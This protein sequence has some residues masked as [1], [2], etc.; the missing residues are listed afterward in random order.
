LGPVRSTNF[1]EHYDVVSMPNPNAVAYTPLG[2]ELHT[3]LANWRLP[4]DFQTLACLKSSVHGG[5]SLLA[6]G[7]KVAE[8]LRR[9]HPEAF[10]LL[11]EQ[12]VEFR[13]HDDSCDI[14]TAVPPITLAPDGRIIQI[15]FNNWLRAYNPLPPKRAR[16]LHAALAAWW[17]LLRLPQNHLNLRLEPGDLI[18]YHNHRVLHG[19][20]P[21]D[22]ASGERHL[23][24]CYVELEDV[25]STWRRL[26]RSAG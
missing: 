14:R 11:T 13:F 26:V 19:R 15:R 6:D 5:E 24:G 25:Q 10:R 1:G 2:L 20:A 8:D 22:A 16:E 7:F 23:Q 18:V 3:D 4:P 21:F 12:P 17:R 9:E